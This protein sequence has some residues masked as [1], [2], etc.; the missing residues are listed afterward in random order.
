MAYHW[1]IHH[2]IVYTAFLNPNNPSTC[3]TSKIIST[4]RHTQ[5]KKINK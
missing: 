4:C 3:N 1:R 2:L 5:K